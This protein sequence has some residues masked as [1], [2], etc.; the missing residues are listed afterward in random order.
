M[1]PVVAVSLRT[2]TGMAIDDY[3]VQ[4]DTAV[5][6]SRFAVQMTPACEEGQTR[7][8]WDIVRTACL[9]DHTV[10]QIV[11]PQPRTTIRLFSLDSDDG[12]LH[13]PG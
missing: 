13:G 10:G 7:A 3:R 12:A 2:A 11:R 5:C 4:L 6:Y 1:I 8:G 9:A